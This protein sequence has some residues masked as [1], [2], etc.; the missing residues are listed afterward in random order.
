MNVILECMKRDDLY[1]S[2]LVS[3]IAVALY[4]ASLVYPAIEW[5]SAESWRGYKVLVL[6]VVALLFAPPLG[7]AWL[8]NPAFFASCA[9]LLLGRFRAA[10]WFGF[11]AVLLGYTLTMGGKWLFSVPW[12]EGGARM[13]IEQVLL[14]FW[15][16]LAAPALVAFYAAARAMRG[17]QVLRGDA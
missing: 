2:L 16:W 11:S 3:A 9:L 4:C 13:N 8:A 5:R 7:G 15:L 17:V 12:D 6:G 10:F 1:W 14:G